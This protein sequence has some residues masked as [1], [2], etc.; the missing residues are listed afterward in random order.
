MSFTHA[1][2]GNS[3]FRNKFFFRAM[4]LAHPLKIIRP[5]SIMAPYLATILETCE[6]NDSQQGFIMKLQEEFSGAASGKEMLSV[7]TRREQEIYQFICMNLTN[8]EIGNR[9]FISEKTVKRHIA[10]L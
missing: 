9:L 1:K 4:E 3:G 10:N 8:K 6:Q 2:G 5:F 7:L